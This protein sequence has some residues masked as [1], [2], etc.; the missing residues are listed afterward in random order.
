MLL[1]CFVALLVMA[2]TIGGIVAIQ[3]NN[4]GSLGNKLTIG[5]ALALPLEAI[6]L[7]VVLIGFTVV[8]PNDSRAVVFFGK[9]IGTIREPGFWWVKPFTM[10]HKVSLRVR[11]FNSERIKVNDA[12]GNP[13]ETSAALKKEV[14]ERLE[15]AGV[16]I[17]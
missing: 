1:K 9:Y 8:Q 11:N 5:P 2:A 3:N 10:R 14:E 12:R 7:F 6:Y 15:A 16:E 13:T 17:V 4:P